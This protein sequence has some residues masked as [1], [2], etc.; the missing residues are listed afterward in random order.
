M[1]VK[2]S[3]E[4]GFMAGSACFSKVAVFCRIREA[5]GRLL[6]PSVGSDSHLPPDH[7]NNH[8]K[9]AYFGVT[10]SGSTS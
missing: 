5:L 8:A 9:P 2:L 3:W 7:N 1:A 10:A 4:R 6:S